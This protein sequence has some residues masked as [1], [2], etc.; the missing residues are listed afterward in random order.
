MH[1]II[2]QYMH[3]TTDRILTQIAAP[4]HRPGYNFLPVTSC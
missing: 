3:E 4:P 2:R 1:Y